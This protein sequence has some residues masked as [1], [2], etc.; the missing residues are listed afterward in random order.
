[1]LRGMGG[2]SGP[3][4]VE[5]LC[6]DGMDGWMICGSGEGEDRERERGDS[7]ELR[8]QRYCMYNDIGTIQYK[9]GG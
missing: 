7:A 1:M 2:T 6:L 4:R 9:S 8:Q 3:S 5:C